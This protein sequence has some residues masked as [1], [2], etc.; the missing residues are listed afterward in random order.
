LIMHGFCSVLLRLYNYLIFYFVFL[1]FFIYH[2]A[3]FFSYFNLCILKKTRL[4][5]LD[6]PHSPRFPTPP[7][8]H[9]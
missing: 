6:D 4:K 1:F 9:K 2:F 3:F 7:D 8:P 5:S